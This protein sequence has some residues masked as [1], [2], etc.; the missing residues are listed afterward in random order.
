MEIVAPAKVNLTLEVLGRRTDG[1]HEIKSV[2]QTIDLYDRLEVEDGPDLTVECD[3]PSLQ[4]ESNLVWQAALALAEHA[5]IRAHA[6][7][8]LHKVIPVGMGLGG[9]SSDAAAALLALDLLW[10]LGLS[11][12]ELAGVAAGVGSDVA[13]FLCGGT[14]FASG[15]GEIVHAV[16]PLPSLPMTLVCPWETIPDKTRRVYASVTPG[17]YGTGRRTEELLRILNGGR[18]VPESMHN[19]LEEVCLGLFPGLLDLKKEVSRAVASVSMVS[20]AGP[21]LFC[22]PTTEVEHGGIADALK[23]Y[24]AR[25]YRV[26][27]IGQRQDIPR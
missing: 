3:D 12:D 11:F 27:T 26:R 14:A 1:F 4:N 13:F 20:G 22:L 23:P 9:G 16:P 17:N 5:R 8:V 2:L 10:G 7:I 19:G 18:F 24:A 6:R 21:A 25:V 15:R